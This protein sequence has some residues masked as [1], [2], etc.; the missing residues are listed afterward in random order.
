MDETESIKQA[1]SALEAQRSLLGDA[2]VETA[3]APLRE[4]LALL[5]PSPAAEQ[6]KLVTVLFADL[7]GFTAIS[8][9]MDPEDIREIVNAYF[10]RWTAC[11]E[12]FG[13]VVEKFIGDAVMAVFGLSLSREGDPESA[14][15]AAL[16]MQ[17]AL[18]ELNHQ[19]VRSREV[20][21][22][23]RVGIHTGTV[24]VSFLGERKGQDFV[25]V[26]DTVNLTSRLQSVAP[27]GGILISH[28]TFRHV[29]GS[30]DVQKLS[31]VQ[32]KGKQ[33][34]IQIYQ[35]IR[36]KR[37]S[38]RDPMRGVEG[39]ETRLIGRDPELAQLN[40]ALIS[41]IEGRKMQVMIV[42]GEA[43]VGKS[44]LIA[45]FDNGLEKLP[46]TIRCFKSRSSPSQQNRPYS[47]LRD[48]FSFRF[49]VYDSDPPQVVQEKIERGIGEVEFGSSGVPSEPSDPGFTERGRL[50]EI[51]M[52]AH[53]IG[54]LLGFRFENSP[55]QQSA[56]L[57]SR[58]FWDRTLTYLVDYFKAVADT[59]PVV[60]L[61]EDIHWA[62]DAS[63]EILDRIWDRLPDEPLL[64]VCA[65][66]PIFFENHPDWGQEKIK[67]RAVFTRI[68]L[69]ALSQ[70]NSQH[71]VE[72]ILAKAEE[73]PAALRDLIVGKA[74]GN[75]FFIEEL[76]KMLM[77]EQVI[78]KE[79]VPWRVDL[80]HLAGVR[81]PST[82]VEVL[83]AR[84]DSLRS[85]E[86]VLLQR[87]SVLGRIFWDD[88]L[89]F[90]EKGQADQMEI[91]PQMVEILGNLSTKEM[92]FSH[93]SSTFEDTREFYFIHTMLRDVTY[94][95]VLKRLRRIYHGYAAA[96]LETITEQSQRSGEFAAQIAE[97]YQ[98]ADD[99]DHARAWYQRAAN[100]AADTYANAESIRCLTHCLALW[101]EE[102]LEGKFAILLKRVRLYDVLANRQAQKQDLEA[103]QALAEVL[104]EQDLN[105]DQPKVSRRAKVFLQWWHFYDSL[106]DL[107]SS[108]ASARHALDLARDYQDQEIEMHGNLYLGATLWRQSDY[109]AAQVVIEKALALARATQSRIMESDC[110]RNLGIILQYQGSY[111]EARA[112]YEEAMQIYHETGNERGESMALNS[113][114][115]LLFDQGLYREALPYFNRSLELK[116]KVGH[117]RAEHITLL[118]LGLLGSKLGNFMDAQ[119]NLE[120]VQ[121][122]ASETGEQDVEAE[123]LNGLGSLALHMGDF[124]RAKT[125]LER[126]LNLAREIGSRASEC[127]ALQFLALHALYQGRY[128][129]ALQSSQEA[130]ALAQETN[131]SDQQ[132]R[133]LTVAAQAMLNLGQLDEA[134]ENYQAA[135]E[136]ARQSIDTHQVTEIQAGLALTYLAQGSPDQASGI[137]LE[138]LD[139]LGVEDQVGPQGQLRIRY[140]QLE[141]LNEPFQVL[142]A[143]CQVL[144]ASHD[145]R[146]EAFLN[147]AFH[148]LLEQSNRLPAGRKQ[149]NYLQR[150]P[151]HRALRE[152][153]NHLAAGTNGGSR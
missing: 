128:Q 86:R 141:G 4:K 111:L 137:V 109:P 59:G 132:A 57:D 26:G 45:E 116:R 106:G 52:R 18:A 94:D 51:Q 129:T 36:A 70:Q 78:L 55:Y 84:L 41:A 49:Q 71:L 67:G 37:R 54:H 113:L 105:G 22:A 118:N 133:G 110:L 147:A 135:L 7:V 43:G 11:I 145:P 136:L 125:C 65:A 102:D 30:F 130:L 91:G 72:E 64:V 24:V 32:V 56:L 150:I 74:E 126:A 152:L 143:C 68:H 27:S 146:A 25:V 82:L 1:M 13:G 79:E 34:P 75:P 127:D 103:L 76:I 134:R 120:K 3:L 38:F 10:T 77:E 123:A 42:V 88:A 53:F 39:I 58:S 73:I 97:H 101:P 142:L 80:S 119:E 112:H 138:I 100:Q 149:A 33:D 62:D 15:R 69:D 98:R 115:S 95:N 21:L 107:S 114:G 20:Q 44:R 19:L 92:V 16:E 17:Q 124:D 9:H 23:M 66:R 35:V 85:E 5:Q 108:T 31:P 151:A 12:R 90:M 40:R 50:P 140:S 122:F 139:R 48:L 63:L 121:Q 153:Y 60:L 148:L 47:L 81:V 29:R 46:Q 144:Q 131:L 2:V 28:D 99:R 14:V 6:R 93:P 96:W 61:L 83:Q 87:A 8:E 104:D 89:S 117:R